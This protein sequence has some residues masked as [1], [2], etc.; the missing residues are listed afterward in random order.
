M[1]TIKN[2]SDVKASYLRIITSLEYKMND[3][4]TLKSDVIG[5]KNDWNFSIDKAENILKLVDYK[6]IKLY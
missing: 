1:K 4:Q 2:C 3:T 5:K 6:I